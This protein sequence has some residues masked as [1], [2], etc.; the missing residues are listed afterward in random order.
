MQFKVESG[1]IL[2]VFDGQE[3]GV[4]L[5][6]QERLLGAIGS[7]HL[8]DDPKEVSCALSVQNIKKIKHLFPDISRQHD[9]LTDETIAHLRA[10]Q[11]LYEKECSIARTLKAD[12][13]A[14]TL[15]S[16]GYNFKVKPFNHQI[17][18]WRFVKDLTTPALFGEPGIGKTA[19]VATALD[20]LAKQEKWIG[21]VVCPVNLIRHV[22][23][24]ELD[25]F[26][27]LTSVCLRPP[28]SKSRA[29]RE[30]LRVAAFESDADVYIV[31]PENLR[32]VKKDLSKQQSVAKLLR[33]KKKEGYK[34]YLIID[35]SSKLKSRTSAVYRALKAIRPLCDRCVIM[36]GTPSPNGVL[37]LWSQFSILDCGKTIQPSFTDYRHDTCEEITLRGVTWKD[38]AGKTRVA[39]KWVPRHAI[40]WHVYSII[41]PRVVRFRTRDCI[42]LPPQ[43]FITRYIELS[44]EQRKVYS[45]M[46]DRLFA[47]LE[48]H[49]ITARVAVSKLMKLR[50]VTGGFV[51]NDAGVAMS[52]GA[53]TPKLLE[54]DGLLEESIA[55][56]MG[57]AGMPAKAL[58]W[59]QY[60][61][62][63]KTLV[64]R[65]KSRY[66]AMGLFGGISLRDKDNAIARFKTDPTMRLLVCHPASAGHGLTLVEAN[67]AFYYSLSYN[68]EEFYQSIRR[69][70][71]PGQKR[72]MMF[73]LLAAQ[74]SIDEELLQAMA[75]KKD[76]SD[77]ITDGKF[78]R[79]HLVNRGKAVQLDIETEVLGDDNGADAFLPAKV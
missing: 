36:T 6:Q 43:R 39:T 42:D 3:D 27:D 34:I 52:L 35:E 55:D 29:A 20:A 48:G 32:A 28:D 56:H 59:A 65:Y 54:L 13:A 33:R 46:E 51:I 47:E 69:I 67:Y 37:D 72:A 70:I 58:V 16:D 17:L 24:D 26:T 79:D 57:D 73:Y 61:W 49:P 31:N 44:S 63:C 19:I 53:N 71:R 5:H 25:R 1:K 11:D 60:Q 66:G 18:G 8:T 4:R 40:G 10:E 38:H 50:E 74:D 7:A 62:E 14:G 68:Y 15:T 22:W 21:L 77:M 45:E 64:E 76:L 23:Q 30:L 78:N 75:T 2:I 12:F 41:E 9:S